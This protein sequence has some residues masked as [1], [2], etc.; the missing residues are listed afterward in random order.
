M[1]SPLRLGFTLIELLVVVSVIALLIGILIPSLNVARQHAQA[2]A[3]SANV[4]GLVQLEILYN[5]SWNGYAPTRPNTLASTGQP[6]W[7]AFYASRILL[8]GSGLTAA[9]TDTGG[10]HRSLKL[11][12]CPADTDPFRLTPIGGPGSGPNSNDLGIGA[13]Y[14]SGPDD[15]TKVQISYGLNT[16]LTVQPTPG[17]NDQVFSNR[18]ADYQFPQQTIVYADSAWV[19]V[20]RWKAALNDTQGDLDYRVALANYPGSRLAWASGPW[21]IGGP[22]GN[23]PASPTAPDPTFGSFTPYKRHPHGNNIGFLDMHVETLTQQESV[24]KSFDG[25]AEHAKVIYTWTEIPY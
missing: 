16:N 24:A 11:F 12:A 17:V 10:D 8:T 3:C 4:R 6:I 2:A 13:L 15:T 19:N 1:K 21:T 23:T 14:G 25:T 7:N 5:E 18:I 9:A 22:D 20:R